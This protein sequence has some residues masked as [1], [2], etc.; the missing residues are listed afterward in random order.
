MRQS[1]V[2]S[3]LIL[4]LFLFAS[5]KPKVQD[6]FNDI[7][8]DSAKNA[9]VDDSDTLG[10]DD[11]IESFFEGNGRSTKYKVVYDVILTAAGKT[12][13]MKET[14]TIRGS[15]SKYEMNDGKTTTATY[16]VEDKVYM[17]IIVDD[18]VCY[19]FE[20]SDKPS[21]DNQGPCPF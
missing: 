21:G 15:D 19:S 1:L 12:T 6:K 20:K 17:C 11:P 14:N 18:A 9:S 13:T 4:I 2:I 3:I 7:N 5:C 16:H 10:S 8:I